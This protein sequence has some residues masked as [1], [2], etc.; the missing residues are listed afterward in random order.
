MSR[1][2]HKEIVICMG[3]SCFSR[4][5]KVSLGIIRNYLRENNLEVEVTFRGAHCLGICEQGP[6]LILNDKRYKR[7]MPNDITGILDEFFSAGK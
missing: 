7:V 4:G 5:N 1:G 3:S 2:E 6:V